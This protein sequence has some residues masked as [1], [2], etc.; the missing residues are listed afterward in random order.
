MLDCRIGEIIHTV[1]SPYF[2]MQK[3]E[4]G[5]KILFHIHK[6]ALILIESLMEHL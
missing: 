4:V 1:G 6:H 3:V 2:Q 5:L